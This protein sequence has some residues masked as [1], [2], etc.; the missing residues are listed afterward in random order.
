MSRTYVIIDES[1]VSSVDFNQV[2]Q[3]SANTLRYN[4]AGDKAVLKY[5]GSAPAFLAGK[6][7]HSQAEI[8]EVL[9]TPEWSDQIDPLG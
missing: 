1:E 9:K 3:T 5:E 4:L 6:Q 7:P 8:V 2:L